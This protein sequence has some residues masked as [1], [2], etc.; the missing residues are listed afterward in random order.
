M[1]DQPHLDPRRRHDALLLFDV[2]DGN[3]NGDPDAGN[4]PRI[5]PETSQGIVTDVAIKRRVRDWIALATNSARIDD[6][7]AAPTDG[8]RTYIQRGEVL[9]DSHDEARKAS[10]NADGGTAFEWMCDNFFDV[11]L[12]GAVMSTGD[13]EDIGLG[14]ARGAAQVT[15]ARSIDPIQQLDI[16]ITRMAVTNKK[17]K[18]KGQTMGRKAITPYGL[19]RSSV[20]WSPFRAART[21]ST[22]RDLELLWNAL[23][24]MWDED[25]SASRGTVTTRTLVVFTHDEPLGNAPA[26]TL[27]DG[28]RVLRRA[29]SDERPARS[30]EDYEI[31]YPEDLPRGV[32]MT[33]IA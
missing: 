7:D 29:S 1:P 23:A 25:R 9:N 18:D 31:T 16:S 15:F 26:H 22:S 5:D 12:F 30:I 20:Y 10:K 32:I 27:L 8:Y 33:R 11:R 2:V 13:K 19:Y 21:R 24:M 28:V 3:P 4:L 17:D 6:P 14:T